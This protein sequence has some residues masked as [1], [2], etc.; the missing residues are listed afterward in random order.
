MKAEEVPNQE[1]WAC[2][3][4][5]GQLCSCSLSLSCDAGGGFTVEDLELQ[6]QVVYSLN[7]VLYEQLQYKGNEFDYYNPL[8]SYIHQ[9]RCKM[10]L[11]CN[12]WPLFCFE[13]D[14]GFLV[15]MQVLQRRTGIPISLSVLYLT[16]ARR[17]GVQLEPVNFPN[18]F[19]LRWCQK[20]MGCVSMFRFVLIPSRYV[21]QCHSVTH[22]LI[23]TKEVE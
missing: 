13:T 2:T 7:S 4:C 20:A 3:R 22:T 23:D 8:N 6:R 9:V 18:H 17:L 19:L 11:I 10:S 21:E 15:C 1:R 12:F 14:E 16:L 5:S